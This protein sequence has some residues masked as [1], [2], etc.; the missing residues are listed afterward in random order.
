MSDQNENCFNFVFLLFLSFSRFSFPQ[1]VLC[2]GVLCSWFLYIEQQ[3]KN[4]GSV[5]HLS[6]SIYICMNTFSITL[7]SFYVLCVCCRTYVLAFILFLFVLVPFF[8]CTFSF[9]RILDTL[10]L[11]LQINGP[12]RYG[13]RSEHR[14][15][16][17][18]SRLE[19][20]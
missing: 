18:S 11:P 14:C 17:E 10:N 2:C 16:P 1:Q 19:H 13:G 4:Y 15:I 3:D 20:M 7:F 6:K 9:G 12:I 8:W 5:I